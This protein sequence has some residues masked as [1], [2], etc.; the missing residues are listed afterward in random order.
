MPKLSI[1]IPIY[2]VEKY[3]RQCIDSVLHSTFSDYE[4][5]LVDDGCTDGSG[6]IC[7]EFAGKDGRI[8]VFHQENGGVSRARNVGIDNVKAP[9]ITFIDADDWISES[10]LD[11]LYKAVEEHPDV[12]FVQA[13]FTNYSSHGIGEVEQS[14]SPYYG[15]DMNF[16]CPIYRGRPYSK[17]L[18]QS[19]LQDVRFDE[20][21]K[22]AEDLIFT[23]DYLIHIGNYA[24]LGEV[25]YYYRCDNENSIMHSGKGMNYNEALH[26]FQHQYRGTIEL[27]RTHHI[28]IPHALIRY[29]QMAKSMFYAIVRLYDKGEFSKE[30]RLQHLQNDFTSEQLSYLK[31]VD[32]KKNRL[33]C[34]LL[35]KGGADIF[36]LCRR[37]NKKRIL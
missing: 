3:L 23:T 28:D 17:L 15:S 32:G 30:E 9:W 19:I 22:S 1:I 16:L 31:Y 8:R 29:Q 26:L 36:D 27:V 4:L 21:I 24:L 6:Q 33:M 37:L 10:F 14:Y 18:K 25:G 20:R 5:L 2:N 7:D 35:Q 13:G 12:D 11:N 34:L